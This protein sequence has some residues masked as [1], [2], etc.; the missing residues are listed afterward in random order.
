M[1]TSLALA[2]SGTFSAKTENHNMSVGASLNH[3][4]Y[5]ER[6]NPHG[7]LPDAPREV[8][9]ETTPGL[10]AQYTYKLGS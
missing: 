3:D 2:S 6:F 9:R 8:A 7:S 4:H 10:Y 1:N 5:A